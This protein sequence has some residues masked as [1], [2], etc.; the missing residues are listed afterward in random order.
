M[1]FIVWKFL[2]WKT[3][4]AA[5]TQSSVVM[6][7]SLESLEVSGNSTDVREKAKCRGNVKTMRQFTKEQS[8]RWKYEQ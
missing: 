3:V 6:I 2:L 4:N 7:A 5:V 1:F 8:V